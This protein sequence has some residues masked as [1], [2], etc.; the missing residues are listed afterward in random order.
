ML[1]N[2]VI[3]YFLI[4]IV[5][6]V[7]YNCS[8]TNTS[9]SEVKV[10]NKIWN[11]FDS[12]VI[13]DSLVSIILKS[14]ELEEFLKKKKPKIVVGKIENSSNEVIDTNLLEKNIERSLINSGIVTFI[15]SKKK[16]EVTRYNRKQRSD[17][18]SKK[19]FGK[20]LKPLK[21]DIFIDGKLKLTIDST[22]SYFPKEYKL[23]VQIFDSKRFLLIT[24]ES[25]HI[26]K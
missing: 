12:E 24:T 3:N 26:I 8:T 15:S 22:N 18:S 1:K 20:Y 21:S 10:E 6:I 16:R 13:A 23:L 5:L 25:V 2:K 14:K 17:F 11:T 4:F 19:E 7:F 9:K